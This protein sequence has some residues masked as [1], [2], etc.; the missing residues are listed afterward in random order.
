[1]QVADNRLRAVLKDEA[2]KLGEFDA[3]KE[4]EEK[5]AFFKANPEEWEKELAKRA[6]NAQTQAKIKAGKKLAR[7]RHTSAPFFILC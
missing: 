5:N 1:M 7:G 3:W 4:R 2:W 6:K